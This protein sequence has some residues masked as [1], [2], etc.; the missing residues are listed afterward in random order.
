MEPRSPA[1]Q[2]GSLPAELLGKP[3]VKGQ[4]VNIFGF[5]T[6]T[7][8]MAT[9]LA[10]KQHSFRL[11]FLQDRGPDGSSAQDHTG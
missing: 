6:I 11:V 2:A 4:I 8:Q 10:A 1:L 7:Q 5:S 9:D 3:S